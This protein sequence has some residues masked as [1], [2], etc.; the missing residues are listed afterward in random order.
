[1][2]VIFYS[3][4]GVLRHVTKMFTHKNEMFLYNMRVLCYNEINENRII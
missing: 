2:S 3:E 4:S 1:M